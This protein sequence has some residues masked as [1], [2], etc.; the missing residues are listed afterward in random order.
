[1]P[2]V[3]EAGTVSVPLGASYKGSQVVTLALTELSQDHQ[4]LLTPRANPQLVDLDPDDQGR[5]RDRFYAASSLRMADRRKFTVWV[6]ELD[7]LKATIETPIEVDW[8]V[9]APA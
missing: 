5:H 3:I 7:R 1:M 9:I 4:I 6:C 8:T 2:V